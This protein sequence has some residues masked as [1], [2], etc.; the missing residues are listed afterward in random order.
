M[1]TAQL[2]A[3][4]AFAIACGYGITVMLARGLG[5]ADFGVYGV[6]ISVLTVVEM[7]AGLGI[8][9]ATTKLIPAAETNAAA[10]ARTG[11]FLLVVGSLVLF[12]VFCGLAPLLARLLHVPDGTTLF[13]VA[14]LDLPLTALVFAYQA[15]LYGHRRFGV[16]SVALALYAVAKLLGILTLLV[17]GL[18]ITDALVANALGTLGAAIYLALRVPTASLRPSYPLIGVLLR[19]AV[20]MGLFTSLMFILFNIDLWVLKGVGPATPAEVGGYVA[21]LNVAR[22]LGVV[23]SVLSPVVFASVCQALATADEAMAQRHVQGAVRFAVITLAPACAM[24]ALKG[25]DIMVTIYSQAYAH[26]GALLGLQAAAFGALGLLD[27]LLMATFAAGHHRRIVAFLGALIPLAVV[28]NVVLVGR[29]GALGAAVGL[30]GIL[31]VG[32]AGAIALALVRY[33]AIVRLPT[34]V[35]VLSGILVVAVADPWL[36]LTGAWLVVKLAILAALYGVVLVVSGE[37]SI[38]DLGAFGRWR[39]STA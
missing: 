10:V 36:D 38:K 7:I 12:V 24:V 8:P 34:L 18:S 16:I 39:T 28:T 31:G 32:A 6:I 22:V 26:T 35:R 23:T 20:P 13:R 9:G 11:N 15:A 1:G 33:G 3:G 4:R 37:V 27:P 25:E 19:L 17:W 29:F 5:P 30:A 21:A 14:F 2:L